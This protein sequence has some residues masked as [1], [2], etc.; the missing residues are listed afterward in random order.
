MKVF[1]DTSIL[2]A[3][4][5]GDHPHHARA[6][7]VL[8]RVRDGTDE[9]VVAGHSLAETYAVLTRLPGA[10]K[11]PGS[12]VWELLA[13]NVVDLFTLVHLSGKEYA[14]WLKALA[15]RGVEGGRVYDALILAAA[16]KSKVERIY[17]FNTNHF[18]A[19]ASARLQDLV[20]S[21]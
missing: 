14:D 8:L 10:G 16:E 20:V 3:A 21:P 13:R 6:R 17:T 1:C 11:V 2:V 18:R 7:S 4:C 12:L 5:L 19:L 9:G 15:L